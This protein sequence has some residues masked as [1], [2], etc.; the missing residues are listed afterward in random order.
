MKHTLT[1]LL[2]MTLAITTYSQVSSSRT[3]GGGDSG[4]GD[5]IKPES[6]SAWFL[7]TET[8]QYCAEIDSKF[9]VPKE[10]IIPHL[11][12]ALKVWHDYVGVHHAREKKDITLGSDLKLATKST[13][14]EKCDGKE[15]LKFYFGGSNAEIEK[16]KILYDN[17]SGFTH[18]SEYNVEKGWGKG[19]VWIAPS[20]SIE[21]TPSFPDWTS[22]YT[23]HG[24]L[25]HEIGHVYG[26]QHIEG[27]IMSEKI[28]ERIK[29]AQMLPQYAF[30]MM[31]AIDQNRTLL[32][33]VAPII[34]GLFGAPG[35]TEANL[36]LF[37]KL[38]GKPS[39]GNVSA[40]LIFKNEGNAELILNDSETVQ[41]LKIQTPKLESTPTTIQEYPFSIYIGDGEVFRALLKK[42]GIMQSSYR[43][44]YGYSILGVIHSKA[45]K[46]YPVSLEVNAL[47]LNQSG[48]PFTIKA[49]VDGE[50][51]Y[52]FTESTTPTYPQ[53]GEK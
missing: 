41:T 35:K 32:P 42:D 39:K 37:T 48:G 49:F 20:K 51:K 6:G 34:H 43:V 5:N 10:D 53:G 40:Q 4:G 15:D 24:I 17:P 31:T 52:L 21:T 16:V 18:R 45:G 26:C 46:E 25:L 29:W 7:G 22:P 9:G 23:L 3:G 1:I 2:L 36:T 38:T 13:L 12:N 14:R 30:W 50:S 19:F 11:Q 47:R 28:S 27:T 44:P 33:T 8:I